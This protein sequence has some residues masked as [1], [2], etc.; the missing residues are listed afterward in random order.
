MCISTKEDVAVSDLNA[1][2]RHILSGIRDL[3]ASSADNPSIF[4]YM[5]DSMAPPTRRRLSQKG[6]AST[7]LTDRPDISAEIEESTILR[8]DMVK[9]ISDIAQD[10]VDLYV[11]YFQRAHTEGHISNRKAI[12]I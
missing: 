4:E 12:G 11:W 9:N 3:M 1:T 8:R 5:Q 2:Y 7:F 6:E 10:E